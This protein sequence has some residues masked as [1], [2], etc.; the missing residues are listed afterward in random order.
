MEKELRA[1][2]INHYYYKNNSPYGIIRSIEKIRRNTYSIYLSKDKYTKNYN[3]NFDNELITVTEEKLKEMYASFL[4]R[5]D[6]TKFIIDRKIE[7]LVHFTDIDNLNS[8]MENGL[9]S[10]E[11]LNKLKIDYSYTDEHRLEDSL[12]SICTSIT[13]PNYKMFYYKRNIFKDRCFAVIKINPYI[14]IH[15]S[16]TEFFKTNAAKASIK[17]D[18]TTNEALKDLFY[19][20]GRNKIP[21]NYTT[22]PQAEVLIKDMIATNYIKAIETNGFDSDVKYLASDYN[23]DYT[24]DGLLFKPR[25][26]YERWR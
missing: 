20:S 4:E 19:E 11:Q 13:Y 7:N 8:I 18:R 23:V 24:Y 1:E 3:Y 6:R 25:K 9:L 15:K 10:I 21:T 2:L 26:D 12:D 16:D 14:M 17:K 22:D 5:K